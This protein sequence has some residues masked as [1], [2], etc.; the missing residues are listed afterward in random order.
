[1]RIAALVTCLCATC[2]WAGLSSEPAHTSTTARAVSTKAVDGVGTLL[3]V[4][5]TEDTTLP[6]EAATTRCIRTDLVLRRVE[7]DVITLRTF[8]QAD[9][10]AEVRAVL[11]DYPEPRLFDAGGSKDRIIV[12]WAPHAALVWEEYTV[13]GRQTTTSRS[14]TVLEEFYGANVVVQTASLLPA[15][16]MHVWAVLANGQTALWS[17]GDKAHLD[18]KGKHSS[19][20]P[21]SRASE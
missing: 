21:A 18:W 3:L 20:D 2:V 17:I 9:L 19:S 14:V 8:R 1:M 5:T 11:A 13:S 7:G 16:N 6:T 15:D 10:T 12:L 4:K